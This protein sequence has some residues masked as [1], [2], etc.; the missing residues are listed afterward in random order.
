MARLLMLLFNSI[1]TGEVSRVASGNFLVCSRC[2][3]PLSRGRYRYHDSSTRM[4]PARGPSFIF[5]FLKASMIMM[6][7]FPGS[8]S[9][10]CSRCSPP[11]ENFLIA[12]ALATELRI[13]LWY[14]REGHFGLEKKS[15]AANTRLSRL[16]RLFFTWF[17]L[18][19]R[20]TKRQWGNGSVARLISVGG[21]V[22]WRRW[23]SGEEREREG[24][25]EG[26]ATTHARPAFSA[27]YHLSSSSPSVWLL[28]RSSMDVDDR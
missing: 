27:S 17:I 6:I 23:N 11:S 8:G 5:S 10:K 21:E 14:A 1:S 26:G 16:K 24:W 25:E 3:C 28:R 22:E 19:L 15:Y 2:P 20:R 4:S 12:I 9:G 18:V 7:E 13:T